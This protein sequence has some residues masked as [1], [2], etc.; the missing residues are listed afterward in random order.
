VARRMGRRIAVAFVGSGE[1]EGEMRA[2]AAAMPAEVEAVFPGFARQD[3]LPQL[4]GSAR[5]FMFP[6]R[7]DPWG[8]VANEACAAGLPILVTPVAGAAKELVRDGENGFVLSLDLD[9]WVDAATTLLTDHDL[10]ARFSMRSRELVGEYNYENAAHGIKN[11]VLAAVGRERRPRVVIIQRRLTH[12]RVPLFD[13][14]RRKLSQ[15][16]IDLVVVYGDPTEAEKEKNDEGSLP[17]GI[18][19]PCRYWFNGLLC[20]QNLNMPTRDADLVIV[21]QENKLLYNYHLL[22]GKRD[23][24]LAFWGHGANMQASNRYS[25]LERWKAWT[26]T[27][28]D[29][30]FAYSGSTVRLIEQY[31]FAQGRITNLKNAIDTKKLSA[32]VDAIKVEDLAALRARLGI[33]DG[34]V[35]LYLGSLYKEKRIDFLLE[36]AQRIADAVPGFHLLVLGDGPVRSQVETAAARCQWLRYPGSVHGR[37]KTLYLCLADVFLNPGMVGLS[38]LDAFVAGE[39]LV[40]TDCGIHSPEIDYLVNGE[41]G[42]VTANTVN[43]Y[44][45]EVTGL[46]RDP[47]RLAYL[48]EGAKQSAALYSI[49]T[50]AENFHAGILQALTEPC[51]S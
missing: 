32:Y 51:A 47:V 25:L 34:P 30:W 11:A 29:W 14:L 37:D 45:A 19:Q 38:I 16:G 24:K 7:W 12:Y 3:Q 4:Y 10:Y 20:W 27:H 6:T 28:V 15:S 22:F 33:G 41:N 1:M 49:E 44:A 18:H 5:I 2:A 50:M 46:L 13:L 9:R 21:T 42:L 23:F 26:S 17:W 36:A 31:G 40:T 39:A 48:R 35:G 8:V 43:A